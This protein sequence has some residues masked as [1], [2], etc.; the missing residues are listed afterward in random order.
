M[1][2]TVVRIPAIGYF[3]WETEGGFEGDVV[4]KVFKGSVILLDMYVKSL[5]VNVLMKIMNMYKNRTACCQIYIG[6]QT[7]IHPTFRPRI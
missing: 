4:S 3:F 6:S 2:K 1:P 5:L 7:R